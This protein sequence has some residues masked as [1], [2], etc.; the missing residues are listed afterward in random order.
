MEEDPGKIDRS[1]NS[2]ENQ[3]L[4]DSIQYYYDERKTSNLN[5]RIFKHKQKKKSKKKP[6]KNKN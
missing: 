6:K 3:S 5:D 4:N 1:E 2:H